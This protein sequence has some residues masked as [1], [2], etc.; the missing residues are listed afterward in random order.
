MQQRTEQ[1]RTYSP[2]IMVQLSFRSE[3]PSVEGAAGTTIQRLLDSGEQQSKTH[4]LGTRY[5][6]RHAVMERLVLF[7]VLRGAPARA[8]D[9]AGMEL[10]VALPRFSSDG[11]TE[12]WRRKDRFASTSVASLRSIHLGC[13]PLQNGHQDDGRLWLAPQI[14][15]FVQVTLLWVHNFLRRDRNFD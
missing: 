2:E 3:L 1:V 7:V 4:V 11:Q 15:F 6:S 10:E 13:Y 9:T 14:V 8:L 5:T 12:H